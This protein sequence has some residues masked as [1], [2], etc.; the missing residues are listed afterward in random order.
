MWTVGFDLTA[1]TS[2]DFSTFVQGDNGTTWVVDMFV[3]N[4]PSSAGA[5]AMGASYAVPGTGGT[6]SPQNYV[7]M[8]RT[9]VPTTSGT[10]YFAVRVNEPTFVPWYLAFD[11]FKVEVTPA[12]AAPTAGT[13][14]VTSATTA[15]LS[16]TSTGTGFEVVVQPAGGS[17]PVTADGTGTSVTGT[18]YSATGLTGTT[19]YEF[20][21]R[22]ECVAGTS[23]SA[24][25]GPYA[26]NTTQLPGCAST[27]APSNG[28]TGVPVGPIT[29][30]WA[31]LTTGDAPTSYDLYVG[32]TPTTV[33]FL[34]GNYTTTTT[35]NDL[36]VNQYN[37]A[38]YWKIVPK[39]VAGSATGCD[40]W[41]F[42]TGPS[43]GY[44]LV[45]DLYPTASYTPANC[46]GVT[47]G[48]ITTNGW[49]GE[50]SLVNVIAGQTYTF[51]SSV[52]SDFITI[53]D[54]AGANMLAS[55]V[56]PVTWVSNI[57][58]QVRFYTHLDNQC[59][60][61]EVSRTRSVICGVL[62]TATPDW[63]NLQH[64]P[65][66]TIT[67]GGS[68]TVYGQVYEGGLTDVAPNIEGQAPGIEA[69]VG[70]SPMGANTNPATWTNWIAATHNSF[71]VGNN[72]EYMAT[73]G[74][75]LAP[76]T[77]YY[78]TRFRLEGGPYVYGGYQNG[79]W[80]GTSNI[81]G[82]LT[83][84][85]APVPGNDVCADATALTPGGVF[86]DNA[87]TGTVLGATTAT[88]LTYACQS[89]RLQDVWYSVVV[90]ASGNVTIQTAAAPG[91][92]L[93]DTVLSVFSGT[94][95]SLTEIA[96][97][98]DDATNNFSTVTLSGQMPGS[99]LYVGVWK[100]NNAANGT[101]QVSAFDASLAAN[102]YNATAFTFY[103][104][105]VKNMLNLAYD[106][107]M[108]NISIFNLLGQQVFTTNV[109]ATE[110]AVDMSGYASGAYI[111]KVTADNQVKTIKVIKE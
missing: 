35:G 43:P 33:T 70:I 64:P 106:K 99:T 68:E 29:L 65:A 36:T 54:A 28:A 50:Y 40:V 15:T 58:G 84:N 80:D 38:I 59:G 79:F 82:V 110:T 53:G 3:N 78:A 77:Y 34:L 49:A 56:T 18:S 91:S 24:W 83:I 69:W 8:R 108:T 12:C 2:Y 52:P 61:A 93:T 104:N 22:N 107:E 45:G 37:T 72:D 92:P 74:A 14:T 4:M 57:T 86:A 11:D 111:V 76:G 81:S 95:G 67:E 100:W 75:T 20:Y 66:I 16:W 19:A 46:D 103:P 51:Q 26:F 94:C 44:C 30:T 88:G 85:P 47:V 60:T 41:T 21:V 48:N 5:T 17:V 73:I 97:D 6:F 90:P 98:D 96:C 63:V 7:E 42:T 10:Y 62:S 87:I 25:S 1:G 102:G 71:S 9:F 55:G 109:S 32:D 23:F 39:N 101:F 27:P 31:A 13:A 89:N 105:P